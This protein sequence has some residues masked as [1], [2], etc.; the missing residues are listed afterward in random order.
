MTYDIVFQQIGDLF[1]PV[2]V[3]ETERAL[4]LLLEEA[5]LQKVLDHMSKLPDK[6][7]PYNLYCHMVAG[8]CEM[9]MKWG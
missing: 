9:A 2:I 4:P 6:E 7:Y 3:G 1:Q 5:I 8:A